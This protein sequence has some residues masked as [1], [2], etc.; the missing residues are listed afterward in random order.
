MCSQAGKRV[1]LAECYALLEIG[2][3]FASEHFAH[4]QD[5][6]QWGRD[7]GNRGPGS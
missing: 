1:R 3:E 2:H 6:K 5:G 4:V 7:E